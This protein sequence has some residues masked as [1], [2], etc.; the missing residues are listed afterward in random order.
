MSGAPAIHSVDHTRKR[1]G[2]VFTPRAVADWMVEWA[3]ANQPRRILEPAFGEGVFIDAL[4]SRAALE[5]RAARLTVDAFDIDPA[6]LSSLEDR[7][8]ESIELRC[9]RADFLEISLD[10]RYDAV[11]ANPP[12]VRHHEHKLGEDVFRRFDVICGRRLSR[13]TNIYGLFLLRIWRALADGGRAAVITPAEWLNAD[14]GKALKAHLLEENA[15]DGIVQFA[16]GSKVF[17]DAMTTAAIT[18]LRRGRAADEVVRFATV[19]SADDLSGDLLA[20]AQMLAPLELDASRKWTPLFAASR[21]AKAQGSLFGEGDGPSVPLGEVARCV[22]GIAT[23]ANRF[24]TLRESERERRRLDRRDFTPC[25]TKA[26][27]AAGDVLSADDMARLITEDHRVLLLKPRDTVDA[28]L[29][30]YLDEGEKQGISRRY[31][32]AHRPVWY[33]PEARPPAPIWVSVFA[34][35]RFRF[36]RNLAGALNL[37]AYHAIYPMHSSPSAVD[38]L[39]AF[40]ASDAAQAALADHR[41]IYAEGLLKVE[42]RD[43]EAMPIPAALADRLCAG[44]RCLPA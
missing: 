9:R 26:Q 20:S 11:V 33:R 36:V 31:L 28:A 42:P 3:C 30:R 5:A 35:G 19:D 15:I 43:V 8:R 41:R 39:F 14:F 29:Q 4:E 18:L 24:F 16:H 17:S 12:Y 40:L 25:I 1:W 27:Q 7:P 2:Q 37:T 22:R 13:L 6:M 44:G 10:R 32:P 34:R 38:E 21:E 23:G